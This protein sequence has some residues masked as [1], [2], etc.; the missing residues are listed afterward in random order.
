MSER[1]YGVYRSA[2][3]MNKILNI[4]NLSDNVVSIDID[5]VVGEWW[6]G[7]DTATIKNEIGSIE[8]SKIVV[9]LNSLG[10]D[11]YQ[12]LAL[13]AML[14]SHPAEV[15]VNIY[16]MAASA[17]TIVAMAG[18]KIRM[19]GTGYFLIH[20]VWTMAIGNA[21]QLE[22]MLDELKMFDRD[23]V[24]MYEKRTGMNRAD[25]E[26]LMEE[27]NGEG[28]WLNADEAR[29]M[30]F[31]DEVYET[32][33]IAACAIPDNLKNKLPEINKPK[34]MTLTEILNKIEGKIDS[35]LGNQAE[36]AEAVEEATEDTTEEA[37]EEATEE[38]NDGANDGA[39][40][41]ASEQVATEVTEAVTA[42]QN[43]V[44]GLE[45]VINQLRNEKEAAEA[46]AAELQTKVDELSNKAANGL[47]TRGEGGKARYNDSNVEAAN[48]LAKRIK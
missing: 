48:F 25:I 41:G 42:I 34:N 36:A 44:N 1:Q 8:A 23:L 9:N 21:N 28:I 12:G 6:E 35:L 19:A 14:A 5:G 11:L 43:R 2:Y 39:N 27:N 7:N 32:V 20:K 3:Y 16:G 4:Q 37:R 13:H 45:E 31:V 22:A 30:G 29:E 38:Q 24:S 26:A 18:D 40:E 15:E 33:K 17:A 46:K 10:G 47:D